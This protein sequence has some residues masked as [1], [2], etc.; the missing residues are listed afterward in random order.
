MGT[1][2]WPTLAFVLRLELLS[3]PRSNK[4]HNR[5]FCITSQGYIGLASKN[6]KIGDHMVVLFGGNMPFVLRQT[7]IEGEDCWTLISKAYVHGMM[8]GEIFNGYRDTSEFTII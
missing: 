3:Q 4:L 2:I 5:Q 8:D 6:A 1:L 7:Q